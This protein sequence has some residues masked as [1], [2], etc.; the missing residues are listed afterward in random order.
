M[1]NSRIDPDAETNC[2][3]YLRTRD[4]IFGDTQD[5]VPLA[6]SQAAERSGHLLAFQPEGAPNDEGLAWNIFSWWQGSSVTYD[7]FAPKIDRYKWLEPRHMG[8]VTD[9]LSRDKTN[10]LQVAFF[11]KIG[12]ETWENIFGFWNGITRVDAEATRPMATIERTIAPF[13]VSP[14]CEA[15]YPMRNFSQLK[16][17]ASAQC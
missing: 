3:C 15:F 11:N 14:E 1:S 13:L 4:G 7:Q 8:T 12:I 16:P 2:C 5:G 6:F 17:M 10:I 9:R